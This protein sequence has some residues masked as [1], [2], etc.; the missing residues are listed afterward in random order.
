M[1]FLVVL[2]IVAVILIATGVAAFGGRTEL[3]PAAPGPPQLAP[4]KEQRFRKRLPPP[5]FKKRVALAPPATQELSPRNKGSGAIKP[6]KVHVD[7]NLPCRVTG[8]KLL[9]CG[10][11]ICLDLRKKYGV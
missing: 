5:R 3:P 11:Q 10:C 8:R 6:K 1:I 2:L 4:S 7:F 9:N